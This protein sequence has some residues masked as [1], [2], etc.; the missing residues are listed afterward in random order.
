MYEFIDLIS[1]CFRDVINSAS[2][3]PT[4]GRYQVVVNV[5]SA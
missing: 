4:F 5:L 2:A 3:D 1:Y